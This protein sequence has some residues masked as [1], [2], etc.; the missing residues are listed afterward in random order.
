MGL[1]NHLEL[2]LHLAAVQAAPAAG[3]HPLLQFLVPVQFLVQV[4]FLLQA[5][6]LALL[7]KKQVP[8]S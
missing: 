4:Q 2:C 5:L 8:L 3:F 7:N 1:L 6:V